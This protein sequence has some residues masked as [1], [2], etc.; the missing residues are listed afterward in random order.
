MIP[1]F[2]IL[3]PLLTGI[4]GFFI[5]E[6]NAAKGWALLSAVLTLVV[7]IAGI[8]FYPSIQQSFDS[9]WLAPHSAVD[10]H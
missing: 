4:V 3:L 9:A 5:K 8:Y 6:D 10:S 1:V 2:L 7:A